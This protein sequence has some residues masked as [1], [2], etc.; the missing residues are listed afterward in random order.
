ML[1]FVFGHAKKYFII[2]YDVRNLPSA[3]F[4]SSD[5][6]EFEDVSEGLDQAYLDMC[7]T[8]MLPPSECVQGRPLLLKLRESLGS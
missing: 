3:E 7:M 1:A 4:I 8:D 6:A 2:N 5:D